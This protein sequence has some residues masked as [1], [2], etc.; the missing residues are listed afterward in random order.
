MLHIN[1]IKALNDV[2]KELKKKAEK[3]PDVVMYPPGYTPEGIVTSEEPTL[4][5]KLALILNEI[6]SEKVRTIF[7]AALGCA[8]EIAKK[9]VRDGLG[10]A[11][12][13]G[14][15]SQVGS[16]EGD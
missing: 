1:Q 7:S 9:E 10:R 13:Q 4:R 12:L 15:R 14:A 5:D 11:T 2:Q 6:P 3:E 8:I 16:K